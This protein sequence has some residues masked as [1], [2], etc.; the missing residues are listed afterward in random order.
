[1]A[2]PLSIDQAYSRLKYRAD[3]NG[4]N[5]YISPDD[6]NLLF[7]AAEISYFNKLY[8]RY[9]MDRRSSEGLSVFS[10]T[11]TLTIDSSGHAPI[12]TNLLRIDTISASGIPVT[13]AEKNEVPSYLSSAFDAP[14]V[15]NPIY[16][17][18]PAY[19][20][21]YP[22][23]LSS[24]NLDA[25]YMLT[26]SFWGY[27]LAGSITTVGTLVGGAAYTNGTYLSVP[28]QGGIGNNATANITVAGGVVT[29][30]VIQNTGIGYLVGDV[31]SAPNTSIGGT[32]GGFLISVATIAV[33]NRPVYSAQN[34]VQPLWNTV[35]IDQII[36]LCLRD[37]GVNTGAQDVEQFADTSM[38]IVK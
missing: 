35:D 23:T 19:L 20:Q 2:K 18:Y 4:Y 26:T 24:A 16:T 34:S 7:P 30:V 36:Y 27:T 29:S 17:P 5:G 37:I 21:F 3:K 25:L 38:Q 15:N 14:T 31:L 11:S 6:F 13:K 10:A 32:G 9:P 33:N 28:L 22:I 12:P 1:M 8:E